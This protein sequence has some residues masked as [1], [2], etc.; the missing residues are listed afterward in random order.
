[1]S[2]SLFDF[3]LTVFHNA[4]EQLERGSGAVLLLPEAGEPPR[5]AALERR[6]RARGGV[7]RPAARL[8]PGDGAD[9]DDHGGVRDGRD[10]VRA[11]RAL[12]RRSTRAAGTTS[13][14]ASRSSGRAAAR[15][16]AG[17]DDGAVHARLHRAARADVPPPR[18]ARDRRDGGVHPVA[19]RPDGE[20]GRA[21]EGAR[22]Q[23]ARVR[24]RLRR[25]LGRAP[26]PRRR[27]RHVAQFERR[28]TSSTGC[29]RTSR[30]T[31]RRAARLR[32]PRRRDH[33][34]GAAHQRL[35]RRPLPRRLARAAP[36]PPRSTT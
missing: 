14:P 4:R 11:A 13:S 36:A 27:S 32:R 19:P 33:R 23:A 12:D 9:R 5:G 28:A 26:R 10:P 2:A 20:R 22:G 25:H 7:A 8:D 6:L 21:R 30:S 3:G 15:P 35:G 17:D 31:E 18:R 24:R 16:G 1:M 34:R 29:A